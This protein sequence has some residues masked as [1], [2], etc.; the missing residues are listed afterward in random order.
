MT[1]LDTGN[2]TSLNLSAI[3]KAG[4]YCNVLAATSGNRSDFKT[5][6]TGTT[7][8]AF[9]DTTP[10]S[11][12]K[13]F[14]A[15]KK[16]NSLGLLTKKGKNYKA[17]PFN[18]VEEYANIPND[19]ISLPQ[20]LF[21][22]YSCLKWAYAT[23][24][25]VNKY[26][27]NQK[28]GLQ[29]KK[30]K[31]LEALITEFSAR[32]NIPNRLELLTVLD[33]EAPTRF[34]ASKKEKVET[35]PSSPVRLALVKNDVENKLK[36]VFDTQP[37]EAEWIKKHKDE[38]ARRQHDGHP[39]NYQTVQTLEEFKEKE[40]MWAVDT[41]NLYYREQKLQPADIPAAI[42][43]FW[44]QNDYS[45][46]KPSEFFWKKIKEIAPTFRNHSYLYCETNETAVDPS[47]PFVNFFSY[48]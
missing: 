39:V 20:E 46:Q 27:L 19:I 17:L 3:R 45:T 15:V 9:G 13:F 35:L 11:K 2:F 1:Q 23:G 22:F 44:D 29:F 25:K 18:K 4:V 14:K 8:R 36:E 38:D 28:V 26:V 41:F 31:S 12:Q 40:E 6:S 37:P 48:G 21:R 16:L 34:D 32:E 30:G 33:K 43:E 47:N 7:M 42:K 10:A 5:Y 24:K